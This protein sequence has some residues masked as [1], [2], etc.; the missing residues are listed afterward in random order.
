LRTILRQYSQLIAVTS[1]TQV[2]VIVIDYNHWPRMGDFKFD[3]ISWP[4]VPGMMNNLTKTYNIPEVK[5]SHSR[6]HT[7]AQATHRP[8]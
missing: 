7:Q 5:R 3:P 6:R 1:I 2:S 4:D 8:Q